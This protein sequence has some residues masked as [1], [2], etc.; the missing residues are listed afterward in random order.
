MEQ[1]KEKKAVVKEEVKEEKKEIKI[2]ED[3]ELTEK[4]QA[5]GYIGKNVG[6]LGTD[7]III[8]KAKYDNEAG[9]MVQ[10][11][12]S[13]IVFE[14]PSSKKQRI[15]EG[16]FFPASEMDFNRIRELFWAGVIKLEGET[17]QKYL[18]VINNAI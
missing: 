8:T 11:V 9:I 4:I 5:T 3:F 18:P 14:N 17:L 15:L 12:K 2:T 6:G 10:T 7:T 13:K 16:N 1:K